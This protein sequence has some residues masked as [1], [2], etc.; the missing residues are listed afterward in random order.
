MISIKDQ[1]YIAQDK[2][3]T[4]L[5]YSNNYGNEIL[6]AKR[7]HPIIT[8]NRTLDKLLLNFIP[9]FVPYPLF[10]YNE[11]LFCRFSLSRSGTY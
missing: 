11:A 6:H 4:K 2:E 7:I 8:Y 3:K 9:L 1:Q 10:W 5:S